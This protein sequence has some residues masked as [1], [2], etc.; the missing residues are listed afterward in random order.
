MEEQNGFYQDIIVVE[1][2]F[3]FLQNIFI[4][5]LYPLNEK[6]RY[7]SRLLICNV[8]RKSHDEAEKN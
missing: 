7:F 2:N 3:L 1:T 4:E 8:T 6:Y 5:P